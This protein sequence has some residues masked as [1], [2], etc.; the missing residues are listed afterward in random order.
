MYKLEL[1]VRKTDRDISRLSW[2]LTGLLDVVLNLHVAPTELSITNLTGKGKGG[3]GF[4]YPSLS[5]ISR[6]SPANPV[7]FGSRVGH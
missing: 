2:T 7:V 3:K 1:A 4:P 6:Q 5:E